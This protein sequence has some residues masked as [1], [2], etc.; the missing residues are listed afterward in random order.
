MLRRFG[1]VLLVVASVLLGV[2]MMACGSA[3]YTCQN[4]QTACGSVQACCTD[5]DCYYSYGGQKYPCNGTDC[6]AAAQ[7]VATIMCA[8]APG[9][10]TASTKD[11][12]EVL[13]QTTKGLA[14]RVAGTRCSVCP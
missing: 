5:K 14:A 1:R 12:T 6:D 4:T 11:S 2:Q 9:A 7:Q 10:L 13:K 8:G 3:S